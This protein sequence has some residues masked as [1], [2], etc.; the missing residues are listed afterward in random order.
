M[1]T[2]QPA[3][4][5]VARD[6]RGCAW[7][8]R[9]LMRSSESGCCS[10]STKNPVRAR[11]QKL[12]STS[13]P[14]SWSRRHRAGHWCVDESFDIH[15]HVVREKL[16]RV[17]G[18]S[19]REALQA[20]VGEL[21]TTPLDPDRPLWQ[22]RL[23]ETYD[24]GSALIARVHH[25]IGDGI[26]LISVMMTITDGGNDP[27]ARKRRGASAEADGSDWLAD[28]LKP[29]GGLS[30]KA[31]GVVEASIARALE[32]LADPQKGL[33]GSIDG[34]RTAAQ[35][36]GDV[37]AMAMMAD[38]APTLLKGRPS[39]RKRCLGQPLPLDQK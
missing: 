28:V 3:E 31:A 12:L 7:T 16:K 2:M 35:V 9:Q 1:T 34:A 8:R 10:K 26:A 23:I 32:G 15:H 38:D 4:S 24:G 36:L 30:A 27:P 18:R 25:C 20:R 29:L 21:A 19:E 14:Q 22:F 39:G 33:A 11:A 6:L 37:T 13:A 17:K 5:E